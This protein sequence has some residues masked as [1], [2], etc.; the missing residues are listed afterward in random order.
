MAERLAQDYPVRP[1]HATRIGKPCVISLTNSFTGSAEMGDR[2]KERSE[3][4]R[5]PQK[6]LGFRAGDGL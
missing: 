6:A 5:R 2:W 4:E 3:V 1:L